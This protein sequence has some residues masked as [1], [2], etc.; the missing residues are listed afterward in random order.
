[1]IDYASMVSSPQESD[2]FTLLN[3][4]RFARSDFQRVL[5]AQLSALQ[6]LAQAGRPSAQRCN[7]ELIKG[8]TLISKA[9][10]RI[11]GKGESTRLH[12]SP[13][14][15]QAARD[16]VCNLGT[17]GFIAPVEGGAEKA[18]AWA[19]SSSFYPKY[20]RLST[21]PVLENFSYGFSN[22][23]EALCSILTSATPDVHGD[24]ENLFSPQ[25][26]VIGL[27]AGSHQSLRNCLVLIACG[28]YFEKKAGEPERATSQVPSEFYPAGLGK[29]I[30]RVGSS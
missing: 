8:Q 22:A 25:V 6:Q 26:R 2:V 28:N 7:E 23:I 18:E 4:L 9:L 16:V 21:F 14:L 19:V 17:F 11:Q 13:G 30:V 15:C 5:N 1:M 12:L 27:A 3:Q 24:P 10:M 20:G 29:S